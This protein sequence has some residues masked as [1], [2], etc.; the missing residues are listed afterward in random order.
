MTSEK[1]KIMGTKTSTLNELLVLLLIYRT[2]REMHLSDKLY[3]WC[4]LFLQTYK[5]MATV[6]VTHALEFVYKD[7]LSL[8]N[9]I[10][11]LD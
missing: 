11:V 4:R 5:F 9:S 3:Y 10:K 7:G 6:H 8:K 1:I 2:N